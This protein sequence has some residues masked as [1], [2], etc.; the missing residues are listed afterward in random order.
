MRFYENPEKTSASRLPERAYYIPYDSEKKALAGV[1]E[2]SAYYLC[3]NGMWDFC[4]YER[5]A[6][7]P[8]TDAI[9][10]R[11]QIPVPSCR[12]MHGYGFPHYTNV[13]YP[14]MLDP[15]YVP[16]DN[17]C[18]VYQK[19]FSLPEGWDGRHTHIVFEGVD[20]CLEL[21]VNGVCVGF[22]QGSRLQAEF[23][24]TPYIK[25]GTNTLLVKVYQ[26]CVGSYLEDQDCFRL[27]G[28]FRDVYL[29]S[30]EEGYISDIEIKA[31]CK[32]ISVSAGDYTVYDAEGKPADL[33]Y[34][35]LWNAEKPYLYTVIVRGKTEYIP[36]KVGM[37]EVSI[38]DKSE[39]CINGVP[40][41]LKG[42]N[43]HDTHPETGY[44]MTEADMRKDLL[45]MKSLNINAVR[46]SHYPPHP[47]FLELCD[48]LGFYVID[49]ADLELHGFV[50]RD[51][52]NAVSDAGKRYFDTRDN[53]EYWPNMNPE[54]EK[55]FL[56]RMTRMVERDKNHPCV[57]MWSS[58]N[59]S[60]F[61]VNQEAMLDWAR[62]RDAS[63]LL[64]SEDASRLGFHEYTDVFSRM[65][66]S[67][68]EM[69]AFAKDDAMRQ[70]VM[71]CEYTHAMGNGP[72]DI[73]DYM[74]LFY[75][76][77]KLIGG[78]I[79][80]WADHAVK[81]PDGLRYGGDFGEALH[82]K[83]FCCDGLVGCDRRL[84]AGSL[85][86][87]YV[88]QN[89]A[90]KLK[91]GRIS[92]TN[93]YDFTDLSACRF[94]LRLNRDGEVLREQEIQISAKPHKT[95]TAE[96][97]F[98]KDADCKWGSY[99]ELVQLG[100]NREELGFVQMPLSE[101]K[102]QP[103]QEAPC[104]AIEE[105]ETD[106][107]VHTDI[108]DYTIDK[109][110]GNF[111][112]IRK[113]GKELLAEP[114]KISLWRACTDNDRKIRF[115]WGLF[116]DNRS[117]ENLNYLQNKVHSCTVHGNRVTVKGMLGGIARTPI[118][119]YLLR[120]D[121][122]QSGGVTVC[123]QAELCKELQ[124]DFFLPRLGLEFVLKRKNNA[125]SYFGMGPEENY[126]DM[127]RHARM[128]LYYSTAAKEYVPYICPQEHGN[129]TKTKWLS[130][131][132]GLEFDGAPEFEFVVSEYPAEEL[133]RKMHADELKKSGYTHLRIDYKDSGLGSNSC[134][135]VLLPKYRLDE[136]KIKFTFHMK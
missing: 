102:S 130:M 107:L 20:S 105:T 128:G 65:Y 134:G 118:L 109:R 30:R 86:A 55:A 64:H 124:E 16:D 74:D 92:V 8:A 95:V 73:G 90:A 23:D 67:T 56:E 14:F 60:G 27:S 123:L 119:S 84:K 39:F 83:N 25:S 58:G 38:S 110:R 116:D 21:F 6:D 47:T 106:I 85:N 113:H 69:E 46:T 99:L 117:A 34:P 53:P 111:V 121:F 91:G 133:T 43:H 126:C 71:L 49:E 135:P 104:N 125:F 120:F 22:S 52:V 62:K 136:K 10:F 114:V 80:E 112:S 51:G 79:W 101:K 131:S 33:Q 59:E 97:P 1:K 129:H 42:V 57:V 87:K 76:Y 17:P 72:G 66:C 29:L 81:T 11:D 122:A 7:I 50:Y 115:R 100:E 40:V 13:N 31:D 77:P 61:G 94:V 4:Y 88:Y 70:P 93:R 28:I 3:L 78:F 96:N 44:T 18:G 63:R 26:W 2:E 89:F 108:C 15:P 9:R 24:I 35:I 36:I 41:K 12:Q 19:T 75:R 5:D 45:L 32:T 37:R 132:G 127:N 98:A 48:E 54:W 68:G 103:L 82:D